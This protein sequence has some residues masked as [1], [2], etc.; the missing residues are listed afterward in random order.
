MNVLI[1]GGT[2]LVGKVLTKLLQEKNYTVSYLSRSKQ[3]GSIKTYH[4]DIDK[5]QID[6]EAIAQADYIVHLAGAGVADK[7]W[8]DSYKK[9]IIDSRVI[10]TQ[11]LVEAMDKSPKKPKAFVSASAVGFYGFDTKDTLLQENAPKGDGFLAAVTEKWENSIEEV[12]KFG[13]RTTIM[14]IGIVLAKEGGALQKIMQPV[15]FFAGSPLGSGKQYMSWI[16]IKDMAR[17]LIYALENESIQGIYNAVGNNPVTNADFTK[18]VAKVMGKP[19][20][21]PNV[22]S[23]ALNLI[24]G[25]MASMVVGGN[26][27]SNE[28]IVNAGFQYKFATL[29]SALKD[30]IS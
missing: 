25:E 1:T 6:I 20:F 7:R 19:L 14:R 16:H 17:M 9:E 28:K 12:S 27:V 2:G 11:L 26:K 24:L 13:V 22:P 8:T 23:F 29:E 5:K 18:A 10:S 30:L 3:S 4:W 21:L 15:Q